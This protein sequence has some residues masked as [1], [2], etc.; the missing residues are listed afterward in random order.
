MRHAGA[1]VGAKL[2]ARIASELKDKV[3][4]ARAVSARAAG[5]R[6]RADRC[7]CRL[8]AGQSRLPPVEAQGA[9]AVARA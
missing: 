6:A 3:A 7:R 8:G 1:G 9:V 5:A 4:P 2:A